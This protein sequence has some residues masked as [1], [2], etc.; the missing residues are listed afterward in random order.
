MSRRYTYIKWLAVLTLLLVAGCGAEKTQSQKNAE[1]SEPVTLTVSA[2]ASLTDAL[3]QLQQNFE[4]DHSDIKLAFNFGASGALQRQIEQGA[5][6]DLFLS[7]A[8]KNMQ[9]L[10]SERIIAPDQQQ[11][12][13]KNTLVAIVPQ[14][15]KLNIH[16]IQDLKQPA[17]KRIAI[18][19]PDSVPAGHYAQEAL[20]SA[21]LWDEL[22]D[23]MVQ[24][25]DVRQ[26][27]QYTETNNVDIGFVYR[28]DAL[29]SKKVKIAFEVETGSYSPIVYP[30]AILK[31][32][33]NIDAAQ[34]FYDY[35]QTPEALKIL[36]SYGFDAA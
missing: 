17:V 13:L 29:A 25:K 6:V 12:W 19:I 3:Q 30:I 36:S 23:K 8:E 32:T 16:N 35:L 7:A 24:G 5:P 33:K 31:S 15:A 14:N 2:A 11:D 1:S 27:L 18:G 28:T 9:A 20:H 34:S 21:G 4:Q 10:V 22:S 26:V